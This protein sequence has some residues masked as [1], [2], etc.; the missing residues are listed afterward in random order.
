MA[1]RTGS[2]VAALAE[3]LE[4]ITDRSESWTYIVPGLT[5]EAAEAEISEFHSTQVSEARRHV[6]D[7]ILLSRILS[8]LAC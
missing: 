3:R 2:Q 8:V 5:Q 6:L 4:P 7:A 1:F